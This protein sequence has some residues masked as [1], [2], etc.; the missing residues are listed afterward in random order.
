MARIIR[1]HIH[2]LIDKGLRQDG[3]KLLDFRKDI[4]VEYGISSKSAEGS[5]RVRLGDTEVVAGVKLGL[6]EPY[7]DKPDSGTIMVGVELSPIANPKFELGPPSIDAI[8]LA[9]VVDRGI[10][11]SG[12]LD[13]KK[14][15]IKEGKKVWFVFID[16]YPIN[17]DGNLRDA[18]SL[19]ALAALKDA[20]FPE[21]DAKNDK[22]DY[23]KKTKKGLPLT[24][25]PLEVTVHKIH[26]SLIVD[27]SLEEEEYSDARITVGSLKE[28]TLCAM[29][30]GGDS[31][32]TTEDINKIVE[33]AVD[34]AKSLRK[35]L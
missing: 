7:S 9:R 16:I 23:E 1:E 13:F 3:R 12:A 20:K 17:D 5:A 6:G 26:G 32:L 34:K 33:I 24:D 11:E 2:S 22:V 25:E 19:A 35:I 30:K 4:S 8:E 21:Y 14:L 10:R 31:P 29:Q 27:P 28:G 15:C 18:S